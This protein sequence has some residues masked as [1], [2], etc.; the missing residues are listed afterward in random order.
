MR[1]ATFELH[2][3]RCIGAVVGD[4]IVDLPAAHKG[5]LESQGGNLEQTLPNDMVALLQRGEEGLASAQAAVRYASGPTTGQ[6]LSYS[7]AD[8]KLKAPIPR[9]G[10]ILAAEFN[11]PEHIREA[12]NYVRRLGFSVPDWPLK[13][14]PWTFAKLPHAVV[15]PSDCIVKPRNTSRLDGEVELAA[16]IGI[17][18]RH[19][20]PETAL[21]FVVGYTVMIDVSARDIEFTPAPVVNHRLYSLGKNNDT[22]APMGPFL[23]TRNEVSDPQGLDLRLERNG[24][25]IQLGNTA[26]MIIS[27]KELV[28]FYSQFF[29]LESGDLILTG[30][31]GGV[32]GFREPPI[33]WQPGDRIAA[34]IS[35][36]GNLE[37]DIVQEI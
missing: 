18:G 25:V 6:R 29:T 19:I 17:P 26:S 9:P 11:Y 7:F 31:P 35:Q 1:L 37:H 2:G 5:W 21:N 10:K 23:V 13:D 14:W 15:G 20:T 34:S 27:L 33:Y 36:I 8:V 3:A 22:F 12:N 4:R 16:V 28:V 32:G 30:T 24:E